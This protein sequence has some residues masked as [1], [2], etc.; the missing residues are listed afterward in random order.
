MEMQ[1]KTYNA[2]DYVGIRAS[3]KI[4]PEGAAT[5]FGHYPIDRF[6]DI[7]GSNPLKVKFSPRN[8]MRIF[9]EGRVSTSDPSVVTRAQNILAGIV[10]S[11]HDPFSPIIHDITYGIV[12]TP[13]GY[14]SS[15]PAIWEAQVS[16]I[17]KGKM[18]HMVSTSFIAPFSVDPET[19]VE[20]AAAAAL[21][22]QGYFR[23][24]FGERLDPSRYRL[25]KKNL[26]NEELHLALTSSEGYPVCTDI[27]L[28]EQHAFPTA[29]LTVLSAYASLPSWQPSTRPQT[30]LTGKAS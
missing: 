3:A 18:D 8:N 16:I 14:A 7:G 12:P 10:R 25:E 5:L 9:A 28:G 24:V 19:L 21:A 22:I 30:T 17:G 2:N 20:P 6:H 4:A 23:Q 13:N 27:S 29:L 11:A 26:R 15:H 1:F